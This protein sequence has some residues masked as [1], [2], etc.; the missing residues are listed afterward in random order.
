MCCR[1]FA[2]PLSSTIVPPFVVESRRVSPTSI[3]LSWGPNSGTDLFSIQYGFEQGKWLYSTDVTGFSTTINNLPP[4]QSIWVQIA[5]R[6]DCRVGT[7]GVSKLIGGLG[8][9]SSATGPLLPN[10][11][12]TPQDQNNNLW[13]IAFPVGLLLIALTSF[14]VF[15]R[16]RAV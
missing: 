6:S 8:G 1:R 4:D 12:L 16:R 10:A 11:G 15:L 2:P 14:V 5:G 7:Y 9:V 13:N 3:F